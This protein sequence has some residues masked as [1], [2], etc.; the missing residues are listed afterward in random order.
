MSA[1]RK[2]T[3]KKS[4][5]R[6]WAPLVAGLL[7][8]LAAFLLY[9]DTLAPTILPYDSGTLQTRA[10]V[11]GIGHPTGYPTFIMLGHL[12]TYL[13]FGDVAYRVNLSSAAYAASAALFAYLAGLR[14]VPDRRTL[15]GVL[16]AATG[17]M[18]FAVGPTL[19]SQAVIT[20][21]YTLNILF[22]AA[23]VWA[24]LLWRDSGRERHLLLAALLAGLAVTA[25]ATSGLLLP[26]ALLFILATRPRTLLRPALLARSVGAGLL[27]LLPYLYLP[28]RASMDPPMNYG[29]ASTLGGLLFILGG[30]NFRGQ[31]FAFGPTE[32]PERLGLYRDLL[33]DQ[34]SPF[35]LL[36]AAVGL[37]ALVPRDRAALV[38]LG[39]LGLGSLAYALEYDIPDIEAYFLP[40]YLVV[41]LLVAAGLGYAVAAVGGLVA[42]QSPEHAPFAESVILVPAL[43]ALALLV[44]K[45]HA[46]VDQSDN[47][48][49]REIVE[50]VVRETERDATVLGGY[51]LAATQYMQYV[52]G[53]R[54]DLLLVTANENQ[55]VERTRAALEMG[56]AY[57]IQTEPRYTRTLQE[58]G[59]GLEPLGDSLYRIGPSEGRP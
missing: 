19:W 45:T 23:T 51:N 59:Y 34:F 9:L 44:P 26:S 38:L 5:S 54:T 56:P 4:A 17:A 15:G 10:Y 58:S 32:L 18:A 57:L 2:G 50:S 12:F 41:A 47:L 24:L 42:R 8:P 6:R 13:P 35:L 22:V 33:T 14:L 39:A 20:E 46:A 11:L 30:G 37:I 25:H 1:E 16:S 28:V 31:M 52:E 48:A 43:L 36:A 55:L 29:D 21:V 40:S 27:G 3:P 49:S 53:R 7:V